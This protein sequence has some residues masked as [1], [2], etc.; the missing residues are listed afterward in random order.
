MARLDA[1]AAYLEKVLERMGR[2]G[3]KHT[4]PLYV[5]TANVLRAVRVMRLNLQ[6][7]ALFQGA[8][9]EDPPSSGPEPEYVIDP[10]KRPWEAGYRVRQAR[11]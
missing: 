1:Y 7:L 3:W 2:L 10:S 4:D 6:R 5:D 9:N 11:Q 8:F